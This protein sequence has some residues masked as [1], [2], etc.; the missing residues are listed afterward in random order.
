MNKG[1]FIMPYC[2]KCGAEVVGDG[3]PCD[4]CGETVFAKDVHLKTAKEITDRDI[5]DDALKTGN[6]PLAGIISVGASA[7][8]LV[9]L[10]AL[11]LAGVIQTGMAD[12][13]TSSIALLFLSMAFATTGIMAGV[14]GLNQ[15][16]K[17]LSWVG[18]ALAAVFIGILATVIMSYSW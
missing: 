17:T 6:R 8:G 5:S 12:W 2:P 4:F 9:M 15:E 16:K 14:I 7:V 3:T 10:I 18:F 1:D 13:T 11:R